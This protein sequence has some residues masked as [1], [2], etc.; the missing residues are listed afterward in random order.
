MDVWSSITMMIGM[1]RRKANKYIDSGHLYSVDGCG[2][3]L[4]HAGFRSIHVC[5]RSE[6]GGTSDSHIREDRRW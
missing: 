4:V 5:R 1:P 3:A 2:G 6:T